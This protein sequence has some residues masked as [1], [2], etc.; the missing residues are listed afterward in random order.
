MSKLNLVV[1]KLKDWGRTS[2]STNEQNAL[3]TMLERTTLS[4]D[5]LSQAHG[6]IGTVWENG[7]TWVLY[8]N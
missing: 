4:E 8:H 3:E 6:G 1:A 2:L 7:P 5:E